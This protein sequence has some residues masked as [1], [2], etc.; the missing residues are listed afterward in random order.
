MLPLLLLLTPT[1]LPLLLLLAPAALAIEWD[2]GAAVPLRLSR[3]CPT[4]ACAAP[5]MGPCAGVRPDERL[6]S[7]DLSDREGKLVFE[8]AAGLP[9]LLLWV[10]GGGRE[11][12]VMPPERD[13]AGHGGALRPAA[14]AAAARR[15]RQ[16]DGSDGRGA[17]EALRQQRRAARRRA[18]VWARV[19][20]PQ[21]QRRQLAVC[22]QQLD[23][24]ARTCPP[25]RTLGQRQR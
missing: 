2:R 21:R 13:V 18:G 23:Q 11:R 3:R 8:N 7:V 17:R 20:R 4:P 14:A 19:A 5:T 15:A 9:V 6:A 1:A 22:A 10:D 12:V 24:R 16:L 25:Q